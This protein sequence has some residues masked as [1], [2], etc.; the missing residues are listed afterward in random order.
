MFCRVIGQNCSL[1]IVKTKKPK[2]EEASVTFLLNQSSRERRTHKAN[3][4]EEPVL[5]KQGVNAV[6]VAP[7]ASADMLTPLGSAPAKRDHLDLT[8]SS[9]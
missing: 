4:S 9:F 8:L 5:Y 6:A 7:S 2:E 3:I 1:D